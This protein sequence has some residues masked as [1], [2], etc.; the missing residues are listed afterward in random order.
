MS[1]AL[2][3]LSETEFHRLRDLIQRASGISLK[4]GKRDLVAGRLARRLRHLGLGSFTAYLALVDGPRANPAEL[5]ELVNCITT[6]KTSFY[7]EPHHFTALRDSVAAR[8]IE[9]AERGRPRRIRIWSAGCS[10]GEEPYTIAMALHDLLPETAGWDVRILATD[11]DTDVLRTAARGSY[12][13]DR[14]GDLPREAHAYFHRQGDAHVVRDDVRARVEFQRLNLTAPGWPVRGPFDA[15]FCRNVVIYFDTA[16]QRALFDRFADLLA[17]DGRLF[18]GH[19]ENLI[20]LSERFVPDGQTIYRLRAPRRTSR[21]LR[22]LVAP[23]IEQVIV[24]DI[25]ASARPAHYTTV[26]GSCVSACIFDPIARVGGMNHFALPEPG[27]GERATTRHGSAAMPQL[28]A[29]LIELGAHRARLCAKLFGAAAVAP[30]L[31]PIDQHNARF[32]R[33]FLAGAQ[34]PI[35]VDHLGGPRPLQLHFLPDRGTVL[36]REV[37]ATSPP[38]LDDT[39]RASS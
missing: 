27:P 18:V 15:I 22:C 6:N 30:G 28:I 7:R 25:R 39:C 20:G 36:F 5:V 29:R 35:A 12:A 8:W 19:S 3:A 10:T 34:I 32:V 2:P 21:A 37:S 31:G 16:T 26:L 11:I 1:L 14:L 24:G 13:A 38:L 17:G 4:D 9:R 23:P 33:E